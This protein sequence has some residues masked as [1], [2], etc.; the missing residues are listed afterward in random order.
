MLN[1]KVFQDSAILNYLRVFKHL[2]VREEWTTGSL[3]MSNSYT[4]Y[5]S[6]QRTFHI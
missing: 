3:E 2:F 4:F 6:R 5:Y 1:A